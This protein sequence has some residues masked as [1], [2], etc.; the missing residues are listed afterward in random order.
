LKAG[1]YELDEISF[2]D[3]TLKKINIYAL[4]LANLKSKIPNVEIILGLNIIQKYNWQFDIQN[5][6]Y[7][8]NSK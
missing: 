2:G 5:S 3:T 7:F 4:D 8:Y 6:Q 1:L